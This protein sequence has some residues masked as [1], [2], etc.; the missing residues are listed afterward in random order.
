MGEGG[1]RDEIVSDGVGI[2]G[3]VTGVGLDESARLLVHIVSD[4]FELVVEVNSALTGIAEAVV[5]EGDID[6]IKI[7]FLKEIICGDEL[8]DVVEAADRIG[9]M[10]V[11]Y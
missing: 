11:W 10:M 8:P 3:E 6:I 2:E 1:N 7:V 4:I 9:T 5:L